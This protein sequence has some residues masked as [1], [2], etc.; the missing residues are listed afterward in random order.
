MSND[1][2]GIEGTPIYF[3]GNDIK[4]ERIPEGTIKYNKKKQPKK[5]K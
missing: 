4:F 5:A 2:S 1:G 3:D